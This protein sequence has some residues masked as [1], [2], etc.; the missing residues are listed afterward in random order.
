M[1]LNHLI[2][3]DKV[4]ILSKNNTYF[5][6]LREIVP[7]RQDNGIDY[8]YHYYRYRVSDFE[9]FKE[10]I[11]KKRFYFS[12]V[13]SLTTNLNSDSIRSLLKIHPKTIYHPAYF[14]S[15]ISGAFSST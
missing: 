8:S 2:I 15:A 1:E 3:I 6:T 14:G 7:Q 13:K 12:K 9:E 11:Q 5:I 10:L 4:S